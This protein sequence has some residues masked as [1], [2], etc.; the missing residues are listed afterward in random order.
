MANKVVHE[1]KG[2]NVGSLRLLP[3]TNEGKACWLSPASEGSV[4]S[5]LADVMEAEQ[6]RDGR[7]VLAHAR[8]LMERPDQLNVHVLKF[9]A[10]RLAECLSDVLRVAESRGIRLGVTDP[11]PGDDVGE[12]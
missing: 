8:R 7:E 12:G 10:V 2:G 6:T 4:I 9:I 11:P 3:W 5:A 1:D